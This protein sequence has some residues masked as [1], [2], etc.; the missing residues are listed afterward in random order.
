VPRRDPI[1]PPTTTDGANAMSTNDALDQPRPFHVLKLIVAVAA[2]VALLIV[3]PKAAHARC[4]FGSNQCGS[5]T[6]RTSSLSVYHR[7]TNDFVNYI[8]VEPDTGETW[9]ITAY[10]RLNE[11]FQACDCQLRSVSASVDVAWNGSAWTATCTGC[12][13]GSPILDVDICPIDGCGEGASL[14]H[15]WS[16]ELIVDLERIVMTFNCGLTQ[17]SGELKQVDFIATDIDDGD[18]IDVGECEEDQAVTLSA[19]SVGVNA[20]DTGSFECSFTC[21]DAAGPTVVILYED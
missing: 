8:P 12:G 6:T 2:G 16:Y 11:Y 20:S 17:Y 3:T 14:D 9:S 21:N 15:S 18:T 4:P 19:T 13:G 5:D 10:Y 1:E 7:Y